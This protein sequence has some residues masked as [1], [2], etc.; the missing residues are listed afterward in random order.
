MKRSLILVAKGR[1][2]V[3][4]I[5]TGRQ[6]SIMFGFCLQFYVSVALALTKIEIDS[7]F[8]VTDVSKRFCEIKR[9]QSSVEIY[10]ASYSLLSSQSR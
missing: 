2:S 10:D 8:V 9:Y 4:S 6:I 3:L 5:K 1:P 7:S